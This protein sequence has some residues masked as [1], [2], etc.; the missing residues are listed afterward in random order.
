MGCGNLCWR[1]FSGSY[2][3]SPCGAFIHCYGFNGTDWQFNFAG[4]TFCKNTCTYN[5]TGA[6]KMSV[7]K[8]P[9]GSTT[10]NVRWRPSCFAWDLYT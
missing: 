2:N 4:D 3:G 1:T 6:M 5:A 10:L 8:L 9:D 7:T